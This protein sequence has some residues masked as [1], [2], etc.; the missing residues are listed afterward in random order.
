MT[1]AAHV[2]TRAEVEDFL[3]HESALLDAWNLDEWLTLFDPDEAPGDE[4]EASAVT[5]A[6][7]PTAVA[8]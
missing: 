7:P 5:S 3:F 1:A 6:M 4:H 2:A 8:A